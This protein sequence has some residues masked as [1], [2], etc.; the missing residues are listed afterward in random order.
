MMRRREF[1]A[2]VA[3]ILTC[4]PAARAQRRPKIA[5]VGYLGLG[6]ASAYTNLVDA[7]RRGLSEH[8]YEEG[9][10]LFIEFRWAETPEGLVDRAAEL[11][12]ANV[13]VIFAPSSDHV[14]RARRVTSKI[15]IIFAAHADPVGVG[16]IASLNRPGG[17]ATGLSMLMTELVQKELELLKEALPGITRVGVLWNPLTPSNVPA[18]KA[19]ESAARS[20]GVELI[21]VSIRGPEDLSDAFSN[22]RQ[23][24]VDAF[25]AVA[26]PLTNSARTTLAQ[27]AL[28]QKM[29]GMFSFK[30]NVVAGGFISYG[31]DVE[32]LFRRAAGYIDKI[33]QG[34]NPAD[35]PVEQASKY[36]LVI[37]LKTAKALGLTIP[38]TLLARADEVIE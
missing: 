33:L 13:D 20:L 4:P 14:E 24:R 11:V 8:G 32:D 6:Q 23:H 29:P 17:N 37:N 28:Q 36:A 27:L 7:F 5:R 12:R 25:L 35:L 9:K 19:V 21:M 18:V 22:M 26:S 3:A 30:V 31:A 38:P 15:P 2:L 10:N 34:A 16:H 1:I